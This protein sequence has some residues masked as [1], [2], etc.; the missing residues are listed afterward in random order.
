MSK[1]KSISLEKITEILR[2]PRFWL[3]GLASLMYALIQGGGFVD[4]EMFLI[5]QNWAL[6]AAGI[7][8]IDRFGTR[9]SE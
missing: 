5:I 3:I 9:F 8:T 2:S 6:G 1:T 4:I 7:G